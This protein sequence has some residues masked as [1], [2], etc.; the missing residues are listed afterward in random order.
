MSEVKTMG[1]PG[2]GTQERASARGKSRW[3]I[4][5]VVLALV[6]GGVWYFRSGKTE[7]AQSSQAAGGNGGGGGRRGGFNMANMVV[8]VVVA[9]AQRGDLPVYYNGLGTVTAFNTVTVRSR[10]DG[11]IMRINFTEGQNVKAGDSLMEIDPRPFQVQLEQAEGQL[12]KDQA[13]QQDAQ[14]NLDRYKLLYK[15]G[16]IPKQQ[17]D[18]QN[19]QVG[20]F[21]GAI[22]SD[23]AAIDNAK[24]Q[25]TYCHITAPISGRIGLR[26][27]DVGNIVHSSDSNG[28]L[29]ITQLQPISVIFTLPQ[30]QLP[31]VA[32]KLR[33][34]A[35]LSV[36][37]FDRDD[38][39]EIEAGK[40]LTIDNQIDTTTG[41]FKLKATFNNEKNLLFPNQFVN[42]HLLVDTRKN[43]MI[44][45]AAAIQRGPQG[46]YVYTVDN[47][48][49]KIQ[50]VTIAQTT[51]GNV[52]LSAGVENGDV[53][54]IDG[55]DKL[56]EGSK[57]NPS[58]VGA[59]GQ[60]ANGQSANGQGTDG[61]RPN[62]AR[63]G[64]PGASRSGTFT[65]TPPPAAAQG[66]RCG[67]G[68]GRT[69]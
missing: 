34:G 35:Q 55:A 66:A 1:V 57:V 54:V 49:A 33:N 15:E 7:E 52:G 53:V 25:I 30:D 65:G 20:Q 17:L 40:L 60:S 28:L 10:V 48:V 69:Q 3:W 41:T 56:Q 6:G 2:T 32:A 47:G 45:P 62:V 44:V 42:V 9:T 39:D 19:A 59:N 43:L 23:Q 67:K 46:T 18:T 27:V 68:A 26:L 16:V 31:T 13:Q 14:V 12:A 61:S 5:L 51:G 22:K 29:V 11:Q 36:Q 64:Q 50:T 8:P 37:A 38:T 58:P 4:W 21:D 24:L 63:Q